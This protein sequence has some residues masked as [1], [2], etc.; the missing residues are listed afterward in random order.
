MRLDLLVPF[1]EFIMVGA[2]NLSLLVNADKPQD[3]LAARGVGM[4]RD[5]PG[6]LICVVRPSGFQF[7]ARILIRLPASDLLDNAQRP[8]LNLAVC[9]SENAAPECAN[10]LNRI[11][12]S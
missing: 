4:G 6:S 12:E 7:D 11:D 1:R 9:H 5:L 8:P 10:L 2:D 3:G